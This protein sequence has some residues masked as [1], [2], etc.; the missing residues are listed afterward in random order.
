VSKRAQSL[1]PLAHFT[2]IPSRIDV[3]STSSHGTLIYPPPLYKIIPPLSLHPRA[4][5]YMPKTLK[6]IP[7]TLCCQV[8]TFGN[9]KEPRETSVSRRRS[10]SPGRRP[11][12]DNS[13]SWMSKGRI[14]EGWRRPS[15]GDFKTFLG[16]SSLGRRRSLVLLACSEQEGILMDVDGHIFESD[17]SQ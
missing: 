10:H 17:A 14:K 11:L 15:D 1:H 6:C 7:K 9:R 4:L 16:C 5:E 2:S 3:V 13:R 8:V 12:Y